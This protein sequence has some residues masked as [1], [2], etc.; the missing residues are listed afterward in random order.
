MKK[1]RA[2]WGQ[3]KIWVEMGTS[4]ERVPASHAIAASLPRRRPIAPVR[5]FVGSCR[6]VQQTGRF[7]ACPSPRPR[8]AVRLALRADAR[9]AAGSKFAGEPASMFDLA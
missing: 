6:R 3:S 8:P 1:P 5:S 4:E 9:T 7:A 2:R